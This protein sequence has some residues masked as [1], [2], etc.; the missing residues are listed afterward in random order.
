MSSSLQYGHL[1]FV[2]VE[3]RTIQVLCDLLFHEQ[4]TKDSDRCCQAREHDRMLVGGQ[5]NA[6]HLHRQPE[7]ALIDGLSP[8]RR[9]D[10]D[11]TSRESSKSDSACVSAGEAVNARD[12]YP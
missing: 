11:T 9:S 3:M 12:I 8:I 2:K 5:I 1:D 10:R 7:N 6:Q 4:H